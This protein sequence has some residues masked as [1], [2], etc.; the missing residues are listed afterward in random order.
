MTV[1]SVS[2]KGQIVLP[3]ET[4]RKLG[5][6]P[7]SQV[8]VDLTPD[9]SGV[10]LRPTTPGKPSRAEDGVGM[11]ENTAGDVPVDEFNERIAHA[12]RNGEL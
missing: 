5:I 1:V 10:L 12:F 3:V 11:V 7:G 6:A 4:R 8:E 2:K 9:G